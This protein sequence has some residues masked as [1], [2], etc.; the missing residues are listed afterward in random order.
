MGTRPER[1]SRRATNFSLPCCHL[2]SP[3]FVSDLKMRIY[4]HTTSNSYRTFVVVWVLY[5]FFALVLYWYSLSRGDAITS[6]PAD[7]SDD[8]CKR[9]R[10]TLDSRV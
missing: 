2:H 6:V 8:G 4:P 1:T 5:N 7:I 9:E 3:E 10:A